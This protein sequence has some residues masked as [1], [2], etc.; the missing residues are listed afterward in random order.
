MSKFKCE[1]AEE[2]ERL[3]VKMS[4]YCYIDSGHV[5][6][7]C[8]VPHRAII[9]QNAEKRILDE[10]EREEQKKVQIENERRDKWNGKKTTIS[11]ILSVFVP[12]ILFILG[13]MIR[14]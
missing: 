8:P 6:Q 11:I 5:T 14:R 4:D 13:I 3:G 2:C 12:A 10:K 7:R 9:K 1:C